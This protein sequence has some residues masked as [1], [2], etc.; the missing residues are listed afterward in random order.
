MV[1]GNIFSRFM[2][3]TITFYEEKKNNVKSHNFVFELQ[4]FSLMF[5]DVKRKAKAKYPTDPP[6]PLPL[7]K[8]K[9]TWAFFSITHSALAE[10][11]RSLV[12][13]YTAWPRNVKCCQTIR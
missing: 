7:K 11:K 9:K 4:T 6:N 8:K 13:D 5:V 10:G 1:N 12:K 3:L 2:S